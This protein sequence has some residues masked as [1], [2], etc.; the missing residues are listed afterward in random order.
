MRPSHSSN[1][2]T[3]MPRSVILKTF[4]KLLCR[5]SYDNYLKADIADFKEQTE[6]VRFT[7]LLMAK[8]KRILSDS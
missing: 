1:R 3:K 2:D 7:P 5:N 4:S 6:N 8:H